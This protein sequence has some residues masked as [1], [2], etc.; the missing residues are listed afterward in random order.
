M[1]TALMTCGTA[2]GLTGVPPVSPSV[3]RVMDDAPANLTRASDEVVRGYA[4]RLAEAADAVHAGGAR[5]YTQGW[6]L[7]AQNFKRGGDRASAER[8][9]VRVTVHGEWPG[10]RARAWAQLLQWFSDNQQRIARGSEALA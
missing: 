4:S 2:E 5:G 10:A 3:R 6:V 7:A 1:L 8:Y 9:L